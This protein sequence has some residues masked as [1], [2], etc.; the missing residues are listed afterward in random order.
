MGLFEKDPIVRLLEELTKRMA[1]MRAAL[2]AGNPQDVLAAIAEARRTL[3]GPM[4][5]TLDRVDGATVVTLMGKEKAGA[6]AG[7]ARL[8]AEARRAMGEEAVGA[9][10]E[11]RASEIERAT[12]A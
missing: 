5:S 8:E 6:Y 11:A 9:R 1:S 10:A 12:R 2:A 3:A 7:L 4:A